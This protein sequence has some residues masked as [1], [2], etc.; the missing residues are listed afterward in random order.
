MRRFARSLLPAAALI[1]GVA[2]STPAQAQGRPD[3]AAVVRQFHKISGRDGAHTPDPEHIASKLGVDP[4][5]VERCAVAYG[6]RVK[7]HKHPK[8]EGESDAEGL[9]AKQEEREYEEISREEREQ[10]AN[11]LQEDLRPGVYSTRSK[12]PDSS[13]EWEP[14]ITHEWEPKLTHE[15]APF[16]RDDDDP[17]F[18]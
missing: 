5:W 18:D 12:G 17:G 8:P 13:A 10:Q 3:C 7:R 11:A 2:V 6:R 16:I 4:E 1:V 15:W 9:T 14:Y